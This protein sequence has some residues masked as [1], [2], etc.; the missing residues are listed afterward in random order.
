MLS[1]VALAVG[2]LAA[3]YIY[4]KAV[5]G[6]ARR[7][8]AT[9]YGVDAGD[10]VVGMYTISLDR[11]LTGAKSFFA[12]RQR[13]PGV[14]TLTTSG[15]AVLSSMGRSFATI[16]IASGARA[17]IVGPVVFDDGTPRNVAGPQGMEPTDAVEIENSGAEPVRFWVARSGAQAIARWSEERV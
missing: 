3:Y 15:Q 10:G 6:G 13:D 17:R 16:K 7:A 5:Q 2:V 8:G 12:A 14:L 11:N 1:T 4:V 9:A